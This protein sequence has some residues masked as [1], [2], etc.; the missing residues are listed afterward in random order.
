MESNEYLCALKNG[1]KQSAKDLMSNIVNICFFFCVL[2]LLIVCCC[3]T[4][5]QSS[6]M[7][8][9]SFGFVDCETYSVIQMLLYYILSTDEK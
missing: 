3:T 8:I 1:L 2:R 6:Y 4:C 5:I 7:E 9:L